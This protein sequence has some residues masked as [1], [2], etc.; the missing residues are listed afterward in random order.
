MVP[1]RSNHALADL[2]GGAALRQIELAGGRIATYPRML[3]AKA[4]IVDDHLGIL[5]SANFDMRSLFLDYEVAL[6]LSTTAAVADLSAW[7]SARA[8]ECGKLHPATR[9]RQLGEDIGRLIAPLV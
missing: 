3:H 1:E 2:A 5:G 9:L 8:A 4:V 6:F 7:F